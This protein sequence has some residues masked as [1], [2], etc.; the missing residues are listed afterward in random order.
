MYTT[1]SCV[2]DST[3][4]TMQTNASPAT[5][6]SNETCMRDLNQNDIDNANAF[7]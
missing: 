7:Y 1:D 5:S 3:I 2:T 4:D 6:T